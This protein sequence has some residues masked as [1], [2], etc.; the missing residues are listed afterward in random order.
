MLFEN[1]GD[2]LCGEFFFEKPRVKR[3]RDGHS[4]EVVAHI[5]IKN[6]LVVKPAHLHHFGKMLVLL[7]ER[8]EPRRIKL[9]IA[10]RGFILSDGFFTRARIARNRMTHHWIVR[11]DDSVFYERI[12]DCAKARSIAARSC[13]TV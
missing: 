6:R 12:A 7:S 11:R 1:F 3:N 10:V 4:L 13:H 2:F 5:R 8:V 9:R